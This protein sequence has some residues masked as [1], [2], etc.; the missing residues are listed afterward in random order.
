M[1]LIELVTIWEGKGVET[2]HVS[3]SVMLLTIM[4]SRYAYHL[5]RPVRKMLISS[6]E[7][8]LMI[9][10]LSILMI[11]QCFMSRHSKRK[12]G[13]S[14]LDLPTQAVRVTKWAVEKRKE[15]HVRPHVHNHII[16]HTF[17]YPVSLWCVHRAMKPRPLVGC[18]TTTLH[19]SP[20]C[21]EI[22]GFCRRKN[23]LLKSSSLLHAIVHVLL[24]SHVC[25]TMHPH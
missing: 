10:P 6:R 15:V 9:V 12:K 23:T 24:L 13:V 17:L 20:Q 18:P 22:C 2:G 8:S 1:Q 19:Y 14:S 21:L 11:I 25:T 4:G 5:T 7:N 3:T 16:M